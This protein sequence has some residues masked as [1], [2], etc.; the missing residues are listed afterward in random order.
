MF[1]ETDLH[2]VMAWLKRPVFGGFDQGIVMQVCIGVYADQLTPEIFVALVKRQLDEALRKEGISPHEA[3]GYD[4][5]VNADCSA[6]VLHELLKREA[7]E[8]HDIDR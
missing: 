6:A 2:Y 8:T 5:R 4:S 3:F 1:R 7:E